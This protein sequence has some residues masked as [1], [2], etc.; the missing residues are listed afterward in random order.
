[1]MDTIRQELP[2][3]PRFVSES[4]ANWNYFESAGAANARLDNC[5]TLVMDM[6]GGTTDYSL[7]YKKELLAFDS[8]GSQQ[9]VI[10]KFFG[11]LVLPDLLSKM[12]KN[13]GHK[14][15]SDPGYYPV[16]TLLAEAHVWDTPNADQ[17][18]G[19]IAAI[20]NARMADIMLPSMDLKIK[21]YLMFYSLCYYGSQQVL[22]HLR[23]IEK[24]RS[25]RFSDI[26]LNLWLPGSGWKL[27]RLLK[28]ISNK[29][30]TE[31]K[32]NSAIQKIFRIAFD[33]AKREA[34]RKELVLKFNDPRL[35]IPHFEL[36]A[37]ASVVLGAL[38][39]S[40]GQK[41]QETPKKIP[42][43]FSLVQDADLLYADWEINNLTPAGLQTL[44]KWINTAEKKRLGPGTWGDGNTLW[45]DLMHPFHWLRAED[46]DSKEQ[47]LRLFD[48]DKGLFERFTKGRYED[49]LRAAHL[50]AVKGTWDKV[51]GLLDTH[52][53]EPVLRSPLG[54]YFEEFN[55]HFLQ[56]ALSHGHVAE[57]D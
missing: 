37:K 51:K 14:K 26:D 44:E 52:E 33:L 23:R 4:A 29:E 32:Q 54:T 16:S 40:D 20:L 53:Q 15:P 19:P 17:R 11:G 1:M 42:I 34:G 8:L 9:G 25:E 45:N 50:A 38:K 56:G 36:V 3:T 30:W 41:N 6:G 46:V 21:L 24:E 35:Q 18:R 49:H 39:D 27:L 55:L 10:R 7:L 48:E 13:I 5:F 47:L 22:Y 2:F 28:Q 43:G 57:W 12:P 31:A